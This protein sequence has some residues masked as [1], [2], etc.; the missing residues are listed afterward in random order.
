M[1]LAM[2][3]IIIIARMQNRAAAPAAASGIIYAAGKLPFDV[4][5]HVVEQER[6]NAFSFSACLHLGGKGSYN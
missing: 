5:S 3:L 4:W 1:T 2:Q 6:L